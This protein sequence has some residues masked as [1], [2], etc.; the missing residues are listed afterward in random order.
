MYKTRRENTRSYPEVV[1]DFTGLGILAAVRKPC[2][3]GQVGFDDFQYNC[4]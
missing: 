4:V 1:A 2:D 3:A